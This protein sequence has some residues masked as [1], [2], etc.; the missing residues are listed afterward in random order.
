LKYVEPF[1]HFNPELDDVQKL[2]T[3]DAQTSGGLL[4][5]LPENRAKSYIKQTNNSSK[6]IGEIITKKSKH[7]YVN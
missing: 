2:I 3:A 6:I 7:I 5:T 4:I 1:I